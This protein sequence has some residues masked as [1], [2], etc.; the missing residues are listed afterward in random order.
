[1]FL[2]KVGAAVKLGGGELTLEALCLEDEI[3]SQVSWAYS[4][5]RLT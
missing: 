5:F 4:G 3:L 2:V 1:M